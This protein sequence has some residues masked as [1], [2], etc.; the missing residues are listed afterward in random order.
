MKVMG[1]GL[2]ITKSS[3]N[4]ILRKVHC[5]ITF[6]VGGWIQIFLRRHVHGAVLH[7]KN[8]MMY[9]IENHNKKPSNIFFNHFH[10]S[11]ITQFMFSYIH[12]VPSPFSFHPFPLIFSSHAHSNLFPFKLHS[13]HPLLAHEE[14][15]WSWGNKKMKAGSEKEVR[16]K[17]DKWSKFWE[18]YNVWRQKLGSGGTESV[19]ETTLGIQPNKVSNKNLSFLV[20][21]IN[22]EWP[23]SIYNLLYTVRIRNKFH[24]Q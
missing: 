22:G 21:I 10:F 17:G 12:L 5:S 9:S 7:T 11:A 24:I 23:T 2:Q 6:T 3:H 8:C 13:I 4:K 19:Q 1:G 16:W 18:E 20:N 15:R 14:R